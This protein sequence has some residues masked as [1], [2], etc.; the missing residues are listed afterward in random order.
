[1]VHLFYDA[2]DKEHNIG[3]CLDMDA[4]TPP[5][6]VQK[7]V[8]HGDGKLPSAYPSPILLPSLT[9]IL[10]LAPKIHPKGPPANTTSQPSLQTNLNGR[11]RSTPTPP[12]GKL[13]RTVS[14][15]LRQ[16]VLAI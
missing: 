6:S 12:T 4:A 8:L 2:Y 3:E 10:P 1:M 7:S 13:R 11:H 14:Q 9:S 15:S 16:G 5:I